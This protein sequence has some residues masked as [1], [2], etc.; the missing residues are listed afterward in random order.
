MLTTT[1]QL[2]MANRNLQATLASAGPV[3]AHRV[4]QRQ[5]LDHASQRTTGP[6]TDH[7]LPPNIQQPPSVNTHCSPALLEINGFF[8]VHGTK[9]ASTAPWARQSQVRLFTQQ[10]TLYSV[11]CNHTVCDFAKR[12]LSLRCSLVYFACL[13]LL[14]SPG[15]FSFAD[16]FCALSLWFG[17]WRESHKDLMGKFPPGGI[18]NLCKPT[19]P[20]ALYPPT[21][22]CSV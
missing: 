11:P 14:P 17:F 16:S 13:S 6:C 18:L 10:C 3:R 9:H 8:P 19:P 1:P 15:V 20:S 7:P 22:W 2:K 21:P 12:R 4:M 5:S